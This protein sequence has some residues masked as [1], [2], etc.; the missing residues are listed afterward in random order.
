MY[1]PSID[2]MNRDNASVEQGTE[3]RHSSARL[4]W[5]LPD[6]DDKMGAGHVLT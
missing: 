4:P 3:R 6:M 5:P 2:I 1:S